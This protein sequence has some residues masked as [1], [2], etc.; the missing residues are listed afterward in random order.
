MYSPNC[1]K[2][3]KSV[4]SPV[5]GVPPSKS[6][7]A[8]LVV[9]EEV[10][11]RLSLPTA[12]LVT[13]TTFAAGLAAEKSAWALIQVNILSAVVSLDSLWKNLFVAGVP[14]PAPWQVKV[15]VVPSFFVRTR[16]ESV[17]MFE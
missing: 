17:A 10:T 1:V 6:V 13:V 7:T 12:A 16:V 2:V 15:T 14:V 4:V 5:N 3:I 8:I 9:S 11:V